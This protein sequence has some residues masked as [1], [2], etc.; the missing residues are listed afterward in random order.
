[1]A[2]LFFTGEEEGFEITG[3][4]VF[5]TVGTNTFFIN[6]YARG[7]FF[8]TESDFLTANFSSSTEVWVHFSGRL[9]GT[10]LFAVGS[11]ITIKSGTT[12]ILRLRSD[13]GSPTGIDF[14]YFDGLAWVNISQSII[15]D[16]SLSDYDIRVIM[17]GSSGIFALYRNDVEIASFIGDTT[18][19]GASAV[20]N[21][22]LSG[23]NSA[24]EMYFS[25]VLAKTTTTLRH[26]VDTLG[27]DGDGALTGLS[28]SSTDIDEIGLV[29]DADFV[30]GAVAEDTGTYTIGATTTPTNYSI[31]AISHNIQASVG[32]FGPQN[33]QIGSYSGGT[34]YPGSNVSG[35]D[36]STRP[37]QLI[38]LVDP[39]TE[40]AWT[41][42]G[43]ASME[44]GYRAKT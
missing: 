22:V 36:T 24:V 8:L 10:N 11:P 9:N 29:N 44:V 17:D 28:G 18:Q 43:V 3:A 4:P 31:G 38:E 5:W 23:C 16:D 13:G 32:T 7:A 25:Q 12:N 20:D 35:I 6:A 41:D 39:D 42:S 21:F 34:F 1:M 40:V 33:L 37:F 2:Y 26:I 14:Q 19:S 27:I 30:S 15:T